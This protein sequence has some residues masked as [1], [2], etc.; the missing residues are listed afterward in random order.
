M[1][2]RC[3][4]R[5]L[6]M[7]DDFDQWARNVVAA[8]T[9]ETDAYKG[10]GQL[11]GQLLKKVHAGEQWHLPES[12]YG[13]TDRMIVQNHPKE[14]MF[15]MRSALD[16]AL[17]QRGSLKIPRGHFQRYAAFS[18]LDKLLKKKAADAVTESGNEAKQRREITLFDN[19]QLELFESILRCSV[20]AKQREDGAKEDACRKP[21]DTLTLGVIASLYFG[22]GK[23]G[24]SLDDLKHGFLSMTRWNAKI[25]EQTA[26]LVLQLASGAKGDSANATR[27]LEQVM[28]HKD[29]MRCPIAM[30]GLYFA[31]QFFQLQDELPT[32]ASWLSETMHRRPL[33]RQQTGSLM[34]P[35]S[36]LTAFFLI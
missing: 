10:V 16:A 17:S 11:L 23:R 28:H 12:R 36:A 3:L 21:I 24:M 32:M 5:E 8:G 7:D 29:P 19:E 6:G 35:S 34:V 22:I 9:D 26:P 4:L 15:A 14:I 27:H 33:L 18:D 13:S 2:A 31:F 1:Y 20:A 25:W 30:L